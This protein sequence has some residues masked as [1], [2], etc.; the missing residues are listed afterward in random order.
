MVFAWQKWVK[1]ACVGFHFGSGGHPQVSDLALKDTRRARCIATQLLASFEQGQWRHTKLVIGELSGQLRLIDRTFLI[2]TAAFGRRL[3][4]DA[5]AARDVVHEDV[6]LV[7][8]RLGADDRLHQLIIVQE[9]AVA[10]AALEPAQVAEHRL[11]FIFE[12]AG[13]FACEVVGV[14]PL[15][16]TRRGG[17]ANAGFMRISEVGNLGRALTDEREC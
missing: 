2:A 5:V 3:P 10:H 7:H 16:D 13:L 8:R 17:D 6:Q 12:R 15:N 9:T 11:Q 14:H 1:E 4:P